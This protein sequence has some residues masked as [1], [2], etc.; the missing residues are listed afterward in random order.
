MIE[1]RAIVATK[2]GF[3]SHQNAVPVLRE[4]SIVNQGAISHQNLNL[5]LTADPPVFAPRMWA[6]SHLA[7]GDTRQVMDRD[8][9]L[10]AAFLGTLDEAITGTITLRLIEGEAEL[11]V[12][13][14]PIDLLART[15]WGGI[16]SMAELLPAFVMPN[17]PAI[18][19]VLKAASDVLRR[20]GKPDAI[21]GY[22]SKSRQRVWQLVAAIW[23]AVCELRLSYALPPA[24]FEHQGQKVR[25]PGAILQG[26]VATC[27]DTTVLFAAALED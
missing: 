17:D 11:A 3:A 16:G 24:S 15:E 8:V 13:T 9:A 20:S 12:M 1:I 6:L 21:D 25:S 14:Y 27:L 22:E 18:D 10:N 19:R 26:R 4:L 5:T 7:P 2:I 23:A